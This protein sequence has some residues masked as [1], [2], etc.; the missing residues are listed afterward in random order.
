MK[1]FRHLALWIIEGVVFLLVLCGMM[2]S[3]DPYAHRERP[4]PD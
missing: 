2:Q 1:P 3:P 4:P